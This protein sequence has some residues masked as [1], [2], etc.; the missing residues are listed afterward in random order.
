MSDTGPEPSTAPVFE[1]G[2]TPVHE[3][4]YRRL[5]DMVMFGD[6]VPGQRVTIQ[7]I[8]AAL[9]A[10]MTPVREAIRRLIAEGALELHENRRIS[11]PRLVEAQ[12]DEVA[13]A[14]HALEPRLAVQALTRLSPDLSA[15]L[16]EID[17]RIDAAM[18]SGDIHGYLQ[19][20]QNFH[21]LLYDAAKAPIL[22]SLARSLWL[23]FGPSLRV[24]M[25]SGAA[26]G[27][28]MHKEALAA[29]DADD[30]TGLASAIKGDIDQGVERV[31]AELRASQGALPALGLQPIHP[32]DI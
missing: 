15:R 13:F 6:L 5:C 22:F 19:G 1:T 32:Q 30:A 29:I 4:T 14:R 27:R 26:I 10:G 2:K 11:V 25:T 8:T 16:R 31:R 17:N 23:R 18:A 28:D 21:F 7:G 20:N 12:L 24:V 9:G 3:A